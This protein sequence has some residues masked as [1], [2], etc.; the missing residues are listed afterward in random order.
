LKIE[1]LIPVYGNFDDKPTE[2]NDVTKTKK[3]KLETTSNQEDQIDNIL[4]SE[5]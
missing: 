5:E 1:S 4:L 3:R 2:K